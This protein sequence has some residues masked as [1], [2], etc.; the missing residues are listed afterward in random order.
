M[1]NIILTFNK[2]IKITYFFEISHGQQIQKI[3]QMFFH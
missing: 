3:A 2:S 1:N